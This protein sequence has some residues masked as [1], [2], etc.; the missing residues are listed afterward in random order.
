MLKKHVTKLITFFLL[1]VAAGSYIF[2]PEAA[3]FFDESWRVLSSGDHDEINSWITGFGWLGPI[4]LIVAMIL[5]MFL[6]IIPS[7]VLMIVSVIAYGPFWGSVLIYSSILVASTVGFYVGKYFTRFITVSIVGENTNNT[8]QKF[9]RKFGFWT[10]IITRLNPFLSNDAIS[11]V[12]GILNINYFRFVGATLVGITPLVILIAYTGGY[13]DKLKTVLLW[14]S[15]SSIIVFAGYILYT[16][17]KSKKSV[18]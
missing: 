2:I 13:V 16:K 12:A 11:F 1:L 10:I 4:I 18:V 5:Q 3:N 7:I 17:L 15:I 8:V 14:I 9:M 6:I